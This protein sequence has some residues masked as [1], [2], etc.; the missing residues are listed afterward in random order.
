MRP[1]AE[2]L[3]AVYP[4]AHLPGDGRASTGFPLPLHA[5]CETIFR[6]NTTDFNDMKPLKT[7][8]SIRAWVCLLACLISLGMVQSAVADDWNLK[9]KNGVRYRLSEQKGKWVLVNFWAP[10][11]PE[12]IQEFPELIA[13]Q[14]QHQDVQVLGVAVMYKNRKDVLDMAAHQALSYPIVLGNEDTAADF[15]GL[16]GLPT[17]FLYAPSGKL[18]GR[19]QGPLT[20]IEVE[21]AIAQQPGAAALFAP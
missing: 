20:R 21:Q 9:D 17:S 4:I 6:L 15:G 18:V 5:G 19:H 16:L 13:L 3:C 10:W 14:Q 12:C 11:C 2:H 7:V 1:T 8:P